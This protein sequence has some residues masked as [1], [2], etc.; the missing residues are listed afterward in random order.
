M[1][2]SARLMT[3]DKVEEMVKTQRWKRRSV[4]LRV[5]ADRTDVELTHTDSPGG[6]A[7][8]MRDAKYRRHNLKRRRI[9]VRTNEERVRNQDDGY[10]I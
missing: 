6:L 10:Q 4:G 7:K 5:S 9:D 8:M 3:D 2:D 1:V